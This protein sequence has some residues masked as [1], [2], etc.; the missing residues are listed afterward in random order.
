[1]HPRCEKAVIEYC[2]FIQE[3]F[4]ILPDATG[5]RLVTPF[6]WHNGDSIELRLIEKENGRVLITD[7]SGTS[8]YLFLSGMALEDSDELTKKAVYIAFRHGVQ[9][10]LLS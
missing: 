5:C 6:S 7:E 4:I 1:M 8:D 10:D 3:Q 9:F 2:T